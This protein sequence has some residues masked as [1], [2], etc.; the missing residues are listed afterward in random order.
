MSAQEVE[1]SSECT[2]KTPVFC[3]VSVFL[4]DDFTLES[5]EQLSRPEIRVR[6]YGDPENPA[7]AVAGGVSAGRAVADV[8]DEKGWWS[9]IVSSGGPVDLNRFCVIGFDFLPYDGETARTITTADQ[10]RALVDA[11][12]VLNI[13]TLHAFVGASYGGMIALVFAE[14]FPARIKNIC[15]V[16]A[17]DRAHPS[18]TAIRGIQRR[19]IKLAEKNGDGQEGVALARQLAM[20][21]YRTPEEFENRF[22]SAPGGAATGDPYDVCDYL[23]ARGAA[24]P[25]NPG[26]YLTLSDSVDRHRADPS[27]IKAKTLIIAATSDRLAPVGDLRRLAEALEHSSIIEIS[28]LYGHDAFLKEAAVIGPHI[29]SFL[30]EHQS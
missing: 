9:E 2:P 7:V 19:I 24:Y 3:D 23:I 30:E 25:A 10:A 13:E 5:G 8:K 12:D 14:L 11:L 18:A 6:V 27:K 20:I 29:K 4:P 16:S 26:R 28:S 15:A 1:P 22:D 17:P 21:S